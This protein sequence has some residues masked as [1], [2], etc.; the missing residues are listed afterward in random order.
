VLS[1]QFERLSKKYRNVVFL[2]TNAPKVR[3]MMAKFKI[4]A[5]PTFTYFKQGKVV[6][7]FAGDHTPTPNMRR[8]SAFRK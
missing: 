8:R 2:K 3:R 4:S 7:Q 1:V 5:F 6:H